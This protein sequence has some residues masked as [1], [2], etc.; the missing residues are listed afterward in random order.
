[1]PDSDSPLRFEPVVWG[2]PDPAPPAPLPASQ[3]EAQRQID[4]IM[5]DREH[6]YWKGDM[7][8]AEQVLELT[9]ASLGDAGHQIV[10]QVGMP[11]PSQSV[12]AAADTPSSRGAVKDPSDPAPVKA[13][14]QSEASILSGMVADSLVTAAPTLGERLGVEIAP[15]VAKEIVASLAPS[16]D[17][18]PRTLDD[19]LQHWPG[20]AQT[21]H[22]VEA[23]HRAGWDALRKMDG[24]PLSA[25]VEAERHGYHFHPK[26]FAFLVE[27]G[28]IVRERQEAEAL[29]LQAERPGSRR[30]NDPGQRR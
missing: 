11:D 21:R 3:Q 27:L 26:A 22:E 24:F 14:P 4:A 20:D 19:E 28:A 2:T 25:E 8:A 30:L 1:M 16:P 15:E 5:A 29:R 10:A 6:P 9:R 23:L 13:E 12:A 17:G 7:Q 18:Y